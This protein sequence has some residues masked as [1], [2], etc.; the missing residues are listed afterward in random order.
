M[1]TETTDRTRARVR[2]YR[3]G[4]GDCFLLTFE[5][6]GALPF[7]ALLDCG[8]LSDAPEARARIR[9][10]AEDVRA[11]TA[12]TLDLVVV[13]HPHWDHVSGFVEAGD[14]FAEMKVRHLWLAWTEDPQDELARRLAG[15]LRQDRQALVAATRLAPTAPWVRPVQQ[16]LELQGPGGGESPA[17]SDGRAALDAVRAWARRCGAAVR[18]LKP[19]EGPLPLP[20]SGPRP[21]VSAY[22][23]G[24]PRDERAL[25]AI[26][27]PRPGAEPQPGGLSPATRSAFR[28]AVELPTTPQERGA[29]ALTYPFDDRVR[30]CPEEA[31]EIPFFRN[32]YGFDGLPEEKDNQA[33]RRIETEWLS[34]AAELALQLDSYANNTSLVLAF[35]L[36]PAGKV[37]LFPADA[38]IGSWLSWQTL[39]PWPG[40]SPDSHVTAA[41]LLARTVLYKVAHHGSHNATPRAE[42]GAA[43]GLESME[44]SELIALLPVDEKTAEGKGWSHMPFAPLL[45]RL[46]EKT[47]G[48]LLRSD[49]P[50][51]F[52]KPEE[53]NAETWEDFQRRFRETELYFEVEVAG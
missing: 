53:M 33:W 14:V 40:R 1:P 20:G 22:V 11:A 26:R 15:E 30:I 21:G 6:K 46:E 2:M 48:R 45:E 35:E 8:V 49:A 43:W 9:R 17:A 37:L 13:S 27:P 16:L 38:Q 47:N 42:A 3:Q 5:G 36:P 25:R 32:Y 51:P 50:R 29:R 23:L 52:E 19:G 12:G 10:V 18:Y 34:T 41:D 31:A 4:L 7:H 28:K 39:P 24:P 44:S